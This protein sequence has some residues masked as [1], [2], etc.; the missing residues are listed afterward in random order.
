MSLDKSQLLERS[1]SVSE[2]EIPGVGTVKARGLTRGEVNVLM[3]MKDIDQNT[4]DR[5]VLSR[6]LVEPKM[7]E[8]DVKAWQDVALPN[9]I[10][11]VIEAVMKLSGLESGAEKSGV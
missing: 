5:F 8:N 7:T 10:G 2:V 9:E 3:G 4:F 6:A 11:N 1:F